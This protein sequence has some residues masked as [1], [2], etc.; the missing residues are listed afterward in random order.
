MWF[1]H[2]DDLSASFRLGSFSIIARGAR[3]SMGIGDYPSKWK[4]SDRIF[5]GDVSVVSQIHFEVDLRP[6]FDARCRI[7]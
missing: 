4:E 2:I 5:T 1:Y 7:L 6:S 3:G